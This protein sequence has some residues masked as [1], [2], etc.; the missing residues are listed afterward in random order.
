MNM[1]ARCPLTNWSN[2][3]KQLLLAAS[4]KQTRKIWCTMVRIITEPRDLSIHDILTNFAPQIQQ[5][6]HMQYYNEAIHLHLMHKVESMINEV[7]NLLSRDIF[8]PPL[9]IHQI[10]TRPFKMQ[11]IHTMQI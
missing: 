8:L 1:I 10:L 2:N 9:L 7:Q 6:H 4:M 5:E 3:S 11:L